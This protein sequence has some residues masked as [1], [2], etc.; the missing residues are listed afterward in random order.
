MIRLNTPSIEFRC[1]T[2]LAMFCTAI[3]VSGVFDDGFQIIVSPQTAAIAAFQAH[4]ATGKLKAVTIPIGP[5]GCHCS[6]I[7]CSARSECM[8]SP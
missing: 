3:A 6:Y 2:R 4:T 7:R 5:S 8:L 1:I